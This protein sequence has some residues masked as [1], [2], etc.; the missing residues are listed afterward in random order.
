MSE[1]KNNTDESETIIVSSDPLF[2][3]PAISK[4]NLKKDITWI[5]RFSGIFYILS[6][7]FLFVCSTFTIK[8][9]GIDLLDALLLR[10]IIQ[11][12]LTF[13]YIKYKKYRL[14]AHNKQELILQIVCAI[15][16]TSGI[17]LFSIALRYIELSDLSTLVYTRV[18]WTVL[19]CILVYRER[20]SIGILLALPLTIFGVILVTKPNFLFSSIQ[21]STINNVNYKFRILGFILA[22]ACAFTSS[23]G[24]LVYKQ[25]ISKSK[26][27]KPSVIN[28]QFSVTV[29]IFLIANQFYK[30]FYLNTVDSLGYFLSWPYLISSI[31]CLLAIL[32]TVLIQKGLKR[33]HPDV[34]SL[35]TSADIIFALILQNIFTSVRSSVC[36]LIGSGLIILSVSLIGLSKIFKNP[37]DKMNQEKTLLDLNEN[38]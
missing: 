12:I 37:T 34:F 20:P 23:L 38:F 4:E 21:S 29:S 28:F 22:I 15:A 7:C 36:D 17:F 16:D 19:L 13:S 35:L 6:A 5:H 11:V 32:G 30:T 3:I 31:V 2:L 18:V 1:D 9:M 8:R 33:E 10:M 14:I 27:I 24:V 26:D 25:L